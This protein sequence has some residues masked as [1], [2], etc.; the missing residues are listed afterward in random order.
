[1][2]YFLLGIPFLFFNISVFASGT[3]DLG[4][5]QAKQH[6]SV[7]KRILPTKIGFYF[8]GDDIKG[9]KKIEKI[10]M[11][12]QGT[13]Y[14]TTFTFTD[15]QRKLVLKHIAKYKEWNKKAISKEV[16]IEKNIGKIE[17]VAA[18]FVIGK[19]DNHYSGKSNSLS[20]TFFSRSKK[21]H[22]LVID[23]SKLKKTSNRFIT[24]MP[25][26]LYLTWENVIQLEET[27]SEAKIERGIASFH[28]KKAVAAD[29]N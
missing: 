11:S 19:G 9:K 1:M 5:V 16:K 29:F 7:L 28:R 22:E 8:F 10:R 23:F 6:N 13:I 25:N 20:F 27:I 14:Y 2:K 3:E 4:T 17:G 12:I 21:Q 24:Y 18:S 26:T 15:A